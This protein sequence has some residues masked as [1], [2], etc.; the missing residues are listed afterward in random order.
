MAETRTHQFYAIAFE[1]NFSLRQL[2]A[3][4]P[5]GRLGSY[6]LFVPRA[7]GGGMYIYRF[8]AVVTH[9]LSPAQRDADL[10]RIRAA[11]PKLTAQV[12]REEYAVLEVP[13]ART[14]IVDGTLHV[15]Q[16]A[17]PRASIV[18]LTMGQSAAMEYYE[19]IVEQLFAR[20]SELV[21]RLEQR[22]TVKLNTR[23]LHRFIGEAIN[24]RSEVLVV[25]HLLDKP[26]AAW[27]DPEMDRIYDDLRDEFDLVVRYATLESKLRSVQEALEL[28]LDV[29]RDRRLVLL[30]V[31]IGVLILV[32]LILSIVQLAK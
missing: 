32:E 10:A 7:P 2:A 15:D 26:E 12:V 24:T 1:E 5:E 11:M 4:F 21:E 16:F 27:D 20:T 28:V 31:A 18:A 13:G 6:E 17:Q 14:A 19:H 3:T 9:D 22:G 29:A 30:E 23:P 25:L 8:G